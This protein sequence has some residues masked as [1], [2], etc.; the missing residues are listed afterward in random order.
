MTNL[1]CEIK[2]NETLFNKLND[3]I[4]EIP[5]L[6]DVL[7]EMSNIE[8]DPRTNVKITIFT[9]SFDKCEN[10]TYEKLLKY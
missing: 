8:L 6:K 7:Q 4:D 2:N 10:N 9:Q 1:S 5:Q 3:K